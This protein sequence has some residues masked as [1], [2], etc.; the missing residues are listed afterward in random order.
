MAVK[1][2]EVA[3]PEELVAAVVELPPPAKV[4]LGPL[5]GAVKVTV[6]PLTGLPFKSCTVALNG[7]AN[8]AFNAALCGVPP[9]GV[10]EAGPLT[11][12][13]NVNC[14]CEKAKGMVRSTIIVKVLPLATWPL[15]GAAAKFSVSCPATT[16]TAGGGGGVTPGIIGLH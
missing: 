12:C 14:N 2:G 13:V 15:A 16:Q 1:T 6:A 3:T 9:E 10:I 11:A 8:G 4:P 7:A 5:A